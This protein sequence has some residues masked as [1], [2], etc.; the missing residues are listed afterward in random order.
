[1]KTEF[2]KSLSGHDKG[3]IYLILEKEGRFA[4][5]ADGKAHTIEKPKKKSERHY[6]VIKAV[7]EDIQIQLKENGPLTD[8]AINRAVKAYER[9]ISKQ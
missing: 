8:T 6:Q 4:Y 1:M 5:L 3:R 9:S 2:A 7:P